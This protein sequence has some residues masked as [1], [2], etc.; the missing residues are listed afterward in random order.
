MECKK[1]EGAVR[2]GRGRQEC[3]DVPTDPSFPGEG[4]CSVRRP[5]WSSRPSQH[6]CL[7]PEDNPRLKDMS[8]VDK[9]TTGTKPSYRIN[10]L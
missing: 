6:V 7:V 10:S 4:F 8:L 1:E 9:G 3:S 2:G 5:L